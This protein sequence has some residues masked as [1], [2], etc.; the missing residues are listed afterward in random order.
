MSRKMIMGGMLTLTVCFLLLGFIYK[1]TAKKY[2][3]IAV[4]TGSMINGKYTELTSGRIG[5]DEEK[6]ESYNL[7]GNVS[8]ILSGITG[9]ACIVTVAG[10]KK[11][12]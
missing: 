5:A 7:R 4:S 9:A 3:G 8:F 2:K 11:F 1:S 10:N 6:Y 12:K